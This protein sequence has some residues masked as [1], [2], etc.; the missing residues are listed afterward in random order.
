MGWRD[1]ARAAWDAIRGKESPRWTP[2]RD[3]VDSGAMFS[4]LPAPAGWDDIEDQIQREIDHGRGTP[5]A[6]AL[7]DVIEAAAL[8]AH[9]AAMTAPTDEEALRL[10]E[11]YRCWDAVREKMIGTLSWAERRRDDDRKR[12][13]QAHQADRLTA[14]K[15]AGRPPIFS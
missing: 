2:R 9:E 1:R 8:S 11:L 5:L 15:A 10:R 4:T 13:R 6:N 14:L 7:L 3:R 12:A